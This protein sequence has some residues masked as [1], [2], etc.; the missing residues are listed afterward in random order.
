MVTD[1]VTRGASWGSDTFPQGKAQ[2]SFAGSVGKERLD[3]RLIVEEPARP[4]SGGEGEL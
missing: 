1:V 2:G 4:V 3:T